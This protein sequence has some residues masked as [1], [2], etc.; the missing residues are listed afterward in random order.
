MTNF[1]LPKS[2]LMMLVSAFAG[3]QT[4]SAPLIS[5]AISHA[6]YRFLQLRRCHAVD[7]PPAL[8]FPYSRM[9][10]SG[11]YGAAIQSLPGRQSG[12]RASTRGSGPRSA[13]RRRHKEFPRMTDVTD[14]TAAAHA[15]R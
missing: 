13:A 15:A 1:H 5:H 11:C 2:T 10:W 3:M 8:A 12:V 14:V 9:H 4:R 7:A 6:R